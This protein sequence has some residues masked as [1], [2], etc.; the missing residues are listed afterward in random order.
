MPTSN[1]GVQLSGFKAAVASLDKYMEASL[2][3]A[4]STP[5]SSV[6]PLSTPLAKKLRQ[7]VIGFAP[8]Y[9]SG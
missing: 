3:E 5:N 7:L 1:F 4:G 9:V 6:S 2:F 8:H